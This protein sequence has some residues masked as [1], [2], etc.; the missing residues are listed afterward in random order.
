MGLFEPRPSPASSLPL[1]SDELERLIQHVDSDESLPSYP[2]TS[3][4]APVRFDIR[5]CSF[6]VIGG[7]GV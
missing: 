3:G 4:P 1:Q 6:E 5:G 7:S 2:R